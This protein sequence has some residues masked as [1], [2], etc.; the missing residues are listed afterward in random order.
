MSMFF[1]AGITGRVGGAAAEQ[2]LNEGHTVRALV[3]DHVK[4]ARWLEQGVDVRQGELTDGTAFAAALEGVDG[5]FVMQPTSIGVTPDFGE[6][7]AL[8][9]GLRDALRQSPPPRVVALSSVG[10]EQTR[11]LGNITQT[12]L[13]EEVLGDLPCSTALVRAGGFIENNL[14]ALGRAQTDGVFDSFLQPT[15]VAFPMVAT[16]DIG[17]QVARLLLSDWNGTKVVELGSLVS[18]DDLARAMGEVLGRDVRASAIPREEWE[19]RLLNMG[20]PADTIGPW[21]EMQDG[22]N[23]GLIHFGVPGTEAVSGTTT[24]TQVFAQA[25]RT[26]DPGQADRS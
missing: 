26:R 17:Q 7:R 21:T 9:A 12:H 18:P 19:T 1:V 11:G 25:R 16:K 3:R 24:P 20:L 5:A 22:F 23:S 8:N 14:G 6:A 15:N 2:L 10:S 13:M 4:A